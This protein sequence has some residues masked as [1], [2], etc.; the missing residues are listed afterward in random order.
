MGRKHRRFGGLRFAGF[1]PFTYNRGQWRLLLGREADGRGVFGGGPEQSDA[2]PAH[3]AV[4]EA[5]EISRVIFPFKTGGEKN[6]HRI[7]SIL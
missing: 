5:Q 7:F 4:R 2:S 1:V 3:A 6:G